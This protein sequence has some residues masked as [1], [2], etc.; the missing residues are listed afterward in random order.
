M[1][2]G[3]GRDHRVGGVGVEFGGV[4]TAKAGQVPGGLDHDALQPEAQSQHRDLVDP[5]E[6]DRA[7]LSLDAAD[8]EPTGDQHALHIGQRGGSAGVADAVVGG[9][10]DDVDPGVVAEPAGS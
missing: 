4:R 6:V 10:P 5:G 7:D 3:H 1:L 9:D 2:V 8:P